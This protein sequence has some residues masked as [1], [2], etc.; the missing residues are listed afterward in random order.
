MV[1]ESLG[2]PVPGGMAELI[3]ILSPVLGVLGNPKLADSN[4]VELKPMT[5]KLTYMTS[6]YDARHY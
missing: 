2:A 3:E 4:L 1:A 6:Q 5:L